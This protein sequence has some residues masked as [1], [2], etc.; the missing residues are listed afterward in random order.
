MVMR[1]IERGSG[2][3]RVGLAWLWRPALLFVSSR[4][5]VLLALVVAGAA[6]RGLGLRASMTRW[7]GGFYLGI[8]KYGYPSTVHG[9]SRLAF[10]PGFPLAIRAV[11]S[12]LRLSVFRASVVVVFAFGLAAACG[13]WLLTRDLA[14]P[15]AAD[16]A[17]ALFV[18][19]PGSF[20]LSMAYSEA[21][22]VFCAVATC[23]ALIHKRWILAG[24]IGA[25]GAATRP[26][27]LALV[28]AAACAAYV[29][30]RDGHR[31][32]P[33]VAVA[34]VASGFVTVQAYF[35][36]HTKD[37]FAFFDTERQ[38]WHHGFST[39]GT[40][41]I[42]DIRSV[43][44]TILHG[45]RPDWNH[46]VPLV[47]LVVFVGA[48][49]ALARWKPPVPLIGYTVGMAYFAF[50]SV[51][52]GFRPRLLMATFPLSMALGA[53][54]RRGPWFATVLAASSAL[55]VMLTIVTATT[56]YLVP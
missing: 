48:F 10:F 9:P 52:V 28:L 54:L 27:G 29:E 23:W 20:V 14:N 15:E 19:A 41:R 21:M 35:W 49:V 34:V 50:T 44:H 37:L 31:L 6:R 36:A 3:L 51:S 2:R 25:V 17:T 53:I 12:M 22:F 4:V 32:R 33:I 38:G 26:D 56:R 18:F 24:V 5:L 45:G 39:L 13:V 55:L 11:E 30:Y 43:W 46:L 42:D 1:A 7:D 47:G 16:R 40:G 8:A